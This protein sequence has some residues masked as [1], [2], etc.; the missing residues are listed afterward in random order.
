MRAR[1]IL[2]CVVLAVAMAATATTGVSASS[3]FKTGEP[4]MVDAVKSGVTV[5]PLLTVGESIPGTSYKLE[6][7]PD[8]ISV[9]P[10]SGGSVELYVNHETSKVPF[11]YN[12]NQWTTDP[13][14]SQSDFDNAQ[15][16]KL[17][18]DANADFLSG[19]FA[20]TTA[21][22]FQR[23]CSNYLATSKEGFTKDILFTNEESPD[24]A[25]RQTNSWPPAVADPNQE[26]NGV[27]VAFDVATGNYHTIYGMGRHNHENDV[28]IPGFD[29]LVVMSGDDTFTSGPL[30]DP[31]ANPPAPLVPAQSQLY[32]YQSGNTKTLLADKGDLWAF[33]S[34]DPAFNDYYDFTP[35]SNASV[36]G[37]FIKVPK[38]IATGKNPDGT[39]IEAADV[40]YP[41]PD[42]GWQTDLRTTGP[43]VAIDGP[44]W[45]LEYWSDT[46]N[47]FSF[48]R[49][50]DIA[51]DKRAGMQNTIYIADTGRGTLPASAPFFGPGLSTNGR[52]WKMV[53]DP[54]NPKKVDSLSVFVEGDDAAV[55]TFLE[56]HQPDNLE[57]TQTGLLVTED[58]GGNNQFPPNSAA[59]ATT[60]R[61]WYV[62]FS[63]A[64]PEIVAKVNQTADEGGTDVDPM[65]NPPFVGGS[66]P[67]SPG[68]WGAW[69]TSGI[70]D[71]S[72]AFG[73][74]HYL[75][76]VQAHT[77]WVQKADG[78]DTTLAVDINNTD[79]DFTYKREGGQLLLLYIPGI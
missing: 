15:V 14:E 20:I 63:G 35:G 76:D 60:A 52:V 22:G 57:T 25:L 46:H 64:A 51:Y 44:Q 23:F 49:V 38:N 2:A 70:V 11:P 32:S 58:P 79:P 67:V 74:G 30:T 72:A 6:A 37:H 12:P 1:A 47:V 3:G 21:G 78:P 45:V 69:E 75:I 10:L 16:S 9:R 8:G 40:G 42:G 19:S 73:P 34:D 50:E 54:D 62:P 55:K 71:A 39:D 18:L 17:T 61:L 43:A 27:V 41:K 53:L 48:V 59:P 5:T 24:Y 56:I 65:D 68:N 66:F 33:V 36:S 7:I 26:E 13:A 77:L 28:A 29:K 4:S 31:L